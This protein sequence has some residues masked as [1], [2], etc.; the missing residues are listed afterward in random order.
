MTNWV[1][2][3]TSLGSLGACSLGQCPS[4]SPQQNGLC[5]FE[6]LHGDPTSSQGCSS[7]LS[8]ASSHLPPRSVRMEEIEPFS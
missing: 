3:T 1:I 5:G 7:C 8:E 6:T 2:K 4:S